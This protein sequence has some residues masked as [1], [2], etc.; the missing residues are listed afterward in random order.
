MTKTRDSNIEL[1]RIVLMLMIILHHLIIHGSKLVQ[2]ASD[3]YEPNDKT[4][5]QLLLNSFI[6]CAVNTFIFISGYFKISFNVK[7]LVSFILQSSFYSITIYIISC[8]CLEGYWS[9]GNIFRACIPILSAQWWLLSIYITIYI[10]SPII[11]IGIDSLSKKQHLFT[12]I[13]LSL[14][15]TSFYITNFNKDS[16]TVNGSAMTLFILIYI[17]GRF[18]KKHQINIKK[19]WLFYILCCIGLFSM[20]FIYYTYFSHVL[21]WFLFIYINP[22]IIGAAITLFFTFN[23]FKIKSKLINKIAPLTF[24]VYLIHDSNPIRLE[25][26]K[27]MEYIDDFNFNPIIWISITLSLALLVF[28]ICIFIEKIRQIIFEPILES[29]LNISFIKQIKI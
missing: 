6:I 7:T 1:L 4:A 11:N 21:A 25:L 5:I 29:I 28:I 14:L 13:L 27:L 26:I 16:L 10:L 3:S 19:G 23:R 20:V 9:F 17:L 12:I 18:F 24:G 8:F 2:L 15:V 22:F